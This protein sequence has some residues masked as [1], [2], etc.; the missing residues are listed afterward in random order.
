MSSGVIGLPSWKV[1]PLRSFIDQVVL[2]VE[3]MLSTRSSTMSPFS[4]TWV[5]LF[6]RQPQNIVWVAESG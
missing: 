5:R 4:S 1:T 3:S 2:S 6:E